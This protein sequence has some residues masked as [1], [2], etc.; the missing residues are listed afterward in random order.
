MLLKTDRETDG[1]QIG[2]GRLEDWNEDLRQ[3]VSHGKARLKSRV[4]QRGDELMRT[5]WAWLQRQGRCQ[6]LQRGLSVEDGKEDRSHWQTCKS[7]MHLNKYICCMSV[8][9]HLISCKPQSAEPTQQNLKLL[10]SQRFAAPSDPS[11]NGPPP[12]QLQLS[13]SSPG[14]EL[15]ISPINFPSR[16]RSLWI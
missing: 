11:R 13:V 4:E 7:L 2:C 10:V 1:W 6:S 8:L 5:R 12:L 14:D 16:P 3:N 9:A 15:H